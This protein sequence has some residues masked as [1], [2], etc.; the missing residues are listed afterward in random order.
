MDNAFIKEGLLDY[1]SWVVPPKII[2]RKQCITAEMIVEVKT[3][4][5]AYFLHLNE[6]D[7]C[8][9]HNIHVLSKNTIIE[10]TT[11]IGFLT[12]TYVKIAAPKYC[13]TDLQRKLDITSNLIEVK[14]ECTCDK[15]K[16]SKVLTV[17]AIEREAEK[18]MSSLKG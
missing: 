11:K 4:E 6:K 14:K 17:H 1:Q 3:N 15:G 18:L 9:K 5:S 16:R 13:I 7:Y 2:H 8:N 10:H 12:G